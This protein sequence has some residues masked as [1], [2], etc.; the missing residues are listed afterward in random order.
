MSSGDYISR[1][2]V[3]RFI[4]NGLNNPD[5]KK[6]FGHDAVEILTEVHYMDSPDVR[7]VVYCRDCRFWGGRNGK[8]ECSLITSL[9]DPRIWLK[10]QPDDFCSSGERR[11]AKMGGVIDEG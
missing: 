3:E 1:Q 8:N 4:E 11:D 5:K 9:A 7:P 2:K 10:T 6:A